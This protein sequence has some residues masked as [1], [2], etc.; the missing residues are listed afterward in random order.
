MEIEICGKSFIAIE[1][2]DQA[3]PLLFDNTI[4]LFPSDSNKED[5]HE[6]GV[7][8]I[9][10]KDPSSGRFGNR[11]FLL[12]ESSKSVSGLLFRSFSS[13]THARPKYISLPNPSFIE[14]NIEYLP[15]KDIERILLVRVTKDFIKWYTGIIKAFKEEM[16]DKLFP[17]IK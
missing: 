8:R 13:T 4:E 17:P 14:D 6:Y 9:D 11:Y 2:I 5:E 3:I 12:I 7:F 10:G 16:I 1:I 15:K